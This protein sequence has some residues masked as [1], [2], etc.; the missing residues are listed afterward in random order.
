MGDVISI[1]TKSLV[2]NA[3]PGSG[4]T[5]AIYGL[6]KRNKSKPFQSSN[7]HVYTYT[8]NNCNTLLKLSRTIQKNIN[9]PPNLI[10]A[11]HSLIGG[12][13]EY[14]IKR[15]NLTFK[16]YST[17]KTF[18]GGIK[19][20]ELYNY[21]VILVSS[22]YINSTDFYFIDNNNNKY[23]YTYIEWNRV[24]IDEFNTER[25][26]YMNVNKVG[27]IWLI[28][29]TW[30]FG[31]VQHTNDPNQPYDYNARYRPNNQYKPLSKDSTLAN[32]SNL[33]WWSR[34]LVIYSKPSLDYYKGCERIINKWKIKKTIK[35]NILNT[36]LPIY[37]LNLIKEEEYNSAMTELGCNSSNNLID[38]ITTYFNDKIIHYEN[39][40][41]NNTNV[42]KYNKEI[43]QLTNSRDLFK[44]R[45]ETQ[46]QES[47]CNICF[48][49]NINQMS[50]TSCC[51]NILCSKCVY[52]I[53]SNN[54]NEYI[55]CPFCRSSILLNSIYNVNLN[56]KDDLKKKVVE[57]M[58]TKQEKIREIC[59]NH[60]QQVLIIGPY[61]TFNKVSS[62]KNLL[63]GENI[64]FS[65]LSG[66]QIHRTSTVN[67]YNIGK[68]HVLYINN[69]TD[70]VGLSLIT[71]QHVI[72]CG[73]P[74]ASQYEQAVSRADRFGR[75]INI[76]LYIHLFEEI[77]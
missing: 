57:K 9:Q 52:H 5:L 25:E 49:D 68:I 74:T 37:I 72:F 36:N 70:L 18:K 60:N 30:P 76:P 24:I 10:I 53:N 27:Y 39:M 43:S 46:L 3:P 32:F 45:I 42:D 48:G 40:I 44:T 75:N 19:I 15:T 21:D 29:G 58:G 20:E 11:N 6:I 12:V 26:M 65:E 2:L 63:N 54:S 33:E 61:N 7:Q 50:C 8:S 14:E 22:K 66:T 34:Y 38:A 28:S 77:E 47:E 73:N 23:F 4:K 62:F 67:D 64:N 17:P 71:T 59:N 13:W 1:T 55:I 31:N 35:N 41:L 51:G 56:V 69:H 16:N